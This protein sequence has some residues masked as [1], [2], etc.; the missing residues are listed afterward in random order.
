MKSFFFTK[1][2]ITLQSWHVLADSVWQPRWQQHIRVS[3]PSP[4]WRFFQPW[5]L[6]RVTF[7]KDAI[8]WLRQHN[9]SNSQSQV[10]ITGTE[11][12]KIYITMAAVQWLTV[13]R[14]Q[15]GKT[16]R[17]TGFT[18]TNLARKSRKWR[19]NLEAFSRVE[20][21]NFFARI[22]LLKASYLLLDSCSY[23]ETCKK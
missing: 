13:Q 22:L 4:F 21:L 14:K 12:K 23:R 19:E 1:H 10:R 3:G 16:W 11:G 5:A 9:L 18:E 6:G 15:C 8:L 20:K 7:G 2:Y 17:E